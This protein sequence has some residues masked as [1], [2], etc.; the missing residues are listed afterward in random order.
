MK[1]IMLLFFELDLEANIMIFVSLI[2]LIFLTIILLNPDS[3]PKSVI[4]LLNLIA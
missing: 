4:L 3:G 1:K 2:M